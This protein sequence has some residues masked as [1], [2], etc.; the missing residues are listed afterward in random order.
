MNNF[1][2]PPLREWSGFLGG[3]GGRVLPE[4]IQ[5]RGCNTPLTIPLYTPLETPLMANGL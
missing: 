5:C 4:G 3:N 2:V 1:V